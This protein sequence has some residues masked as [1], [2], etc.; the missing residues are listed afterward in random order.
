MRKM[1][2]MGILMIIPFLLLSI[3][4]NS[5]NKIV[6]HTDQPGSTID[7]AIYGQFAEHLGHC[8][9]GGIYVGEKSDIPNKDGF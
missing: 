9:Y 4:G 6:V 3:S 8:I 5:Q 1:N 7:K 2:C